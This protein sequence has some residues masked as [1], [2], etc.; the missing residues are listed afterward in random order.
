MKK[1]YVVAAILFLL[2]GFASVVTNLFLNGTIKFSYNQELFDKGIVF[3]YAKTKK[4]QAFIEDD[5]KSISYETSVLST[6]NETST[7]EYEVSNKSK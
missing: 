6:L 3:T 1:T 4:G 5:G 7:L 2:V